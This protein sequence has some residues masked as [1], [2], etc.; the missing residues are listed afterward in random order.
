MRAA[1]TRNTL[2]RC[3]LLHAQ[4]TSCCIGLSSLFRLYSKLVADVRLARVMSRCKSVLITL[5]MQ[6]EH[7]CKY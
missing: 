3:N 1:S 2:G 6:I 4:V 7:S 5:V